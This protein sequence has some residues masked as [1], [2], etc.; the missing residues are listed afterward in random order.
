MSFTLTQKG[1][2]TVREIRAKIEYLR[3]E[4]QNNTLERVI[5]ELGHIPL[6][7]VMFAAGQSTP[8]DL[9]EMVKQGYASYR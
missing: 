5:F 6:P 9:T 3:P 7:V 8:S 1:E 4:Y 2:I